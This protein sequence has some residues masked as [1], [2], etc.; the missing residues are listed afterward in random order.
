MERPSK[1]GMIRSWRFPVTLKS[2]VDATIFAISA[3]LAFELRFDGTLPAAFVHGLPVFAS[4]AIAIKTATFLLAHV[5]RCSWRLVSSSDLTRICAANLVGSILISFILILIYD[6][7]LAPRVVYFI[8]LL[9][10]TSLTISVRLLFRAAM[11]SRLSFSTGELQRVLVYG[12]GSAGQALVHEICTN[13]ELGCRIVGLVDDDRHKKGQLWSGVRVFGTGEDLH[14]LVVSHRVDRILI[15]VPSASSQQ[16]AEILKRVA[17]C[18]VDYQ[19]IPGL[20]ELMQG[21]ELNRQ[22]RSVAVEDLL[23]RK[24]VQ[25]DR[26]AI[27][28]R[29]HGRV[30]MVT[31]A[32]GSIGSEICRQIA[33]FHPLALIGFDSAETPLFHLERELKAKFPDL[34]FHPEIGSVA[35]LDSLTWAMQRHHPAILYHAAAYKHV[36][37]ME[38]HVFSAVENNIFGTWRTCQAASRCGVETFVLISTDKAVRPTSVMGTTKRIAE[39]AIRSAGVRS[40]TRFMAVRFGNVLGSNGSVVPIFKEQILAGGPVTVTHP[41]MRR[42]FMTIPEAAQLVIQASIMGEGGE[43]FELDMGEQV[44]IVDLARNLILLSGLKPERDIEIHYTGVRPG[45]KLYEE[46]N[47][48]HENLVATSHPK[49]LSYVSPV[50][51]DPEMIKTSLQQLHIYFEERDLAS[52]LGLMR[53][54]VPEYTPS[55]ELLLASEGVPA[56]VN[57]FDPRPARSAGPELAVSR[58]RYHV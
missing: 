17:A 56:R 5:N 4:V 3:I 43:V 20:G 13:R 23:G 19:T 33:R 2:L 26:E 49:I 18:D 30:V 57:L 28:H 48:D 47:L 42:F 40:N 37:L 15:A 55:A 35:R 27:D 46:L 58:E 39:L 11:H 9:L 16:M 32:A 38:K 44:R 7:S 24:P 52:L 8:D 29:I 31:G 53:E 10:A 22:I 12:A 14:K 51:S 54:L 1:P 25:L 45:E 50:E 41:E 34:N 36:P 6:G 21:T